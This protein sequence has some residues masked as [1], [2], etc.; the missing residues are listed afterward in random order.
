M[1]RNDSASNTLWNKSKIQSIDELFLAIKLYEY[2]INCLKL[3][4]DMVAYE[5][6]LVQF[7]GMLWARTNN[8]P[9]ILRRSVFTV[10][11]HYLISLRYKDFKAS[12]FLLS[13]ANQCLIKGDFKS[14]DI[15]GR[16]C[17]NIR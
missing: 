15:I 7:S 1:V 2:S 6:L 4:N 12:T 16:L 13:Q 10:A 8:L 9:I 11:S 17:Y 3:P 5:M 14:W